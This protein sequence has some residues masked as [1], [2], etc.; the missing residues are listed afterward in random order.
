MTLGMLHEPTSEA[1]WAKAVLIDFFVTS[2]RV[3]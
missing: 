2:A 3:I 1:S